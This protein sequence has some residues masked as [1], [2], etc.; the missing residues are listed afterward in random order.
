L[1]IEKLSTGRRKVIHRLH[2]KNTVNIKTVDNRLFLCIF[3]V[4]LINVLKM[5]DK[6]KKILYNSYT[7]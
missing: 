1:E 7:Y 6:Q 2:N 4:F 3:V 5:F